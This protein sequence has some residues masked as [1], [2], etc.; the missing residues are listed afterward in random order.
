MLQFCGNDPKILLE[1]AL[2]AEDYCDAIDINLG[3]PQAI[4]RRGH[5]GSFLQDEWDL[6]ADIVSTLN[7]E[8]KVPITCKVRVFEDLERTVKYAQ[9]LESAGC[10]LL[11]VH[12]RTREQKGPLTGLADW[13]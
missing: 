11:T 13:N 2:L 8:L 12:G 1:A 10:T 5:Y 9:M 7:K 4:A 6:L 3:C